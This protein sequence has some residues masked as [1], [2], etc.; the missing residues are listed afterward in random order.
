M[1]PFILIHGKLNADSYSNFRDN[2]VL[3]TVRQFYGLDYCYLMDYNSTCHVVRHESFKRTYRIGEESHC[4]EKR[5]KREQATGSSQL[6]IDAEIDDLKNITSEELTASGGTDNSEKQSKSSSPNK[7]IRRMTDADILDN[8][9]VFFIAAN[10]GCGSPVVKVSD[11]GR[12]VMS[13]S[14]VPLKTHRVGQRC[15]L[16][17]S[18]A[19]TSS[20][21]CGRRGGAGSD[22]MHVT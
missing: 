16:N 10:R 1:D 13:S 8:S 7:L 3:P 17:M 9:V 21:W 4:N 2:N 6:M 11:H 5:Q 12:R 15:T 20:R 22:V 14:P 18:R 19:E